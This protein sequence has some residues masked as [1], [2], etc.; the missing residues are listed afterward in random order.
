MNL[1]KDKVVVVTGGSSGI[2]RATVR[3]L[4]EGGAKVVIG[5][6]Q[7]CPD[8]FAG[9]G[10]AVF[11]TT[12]V[13]E[14]P[15]IDALIGEAIDRY[16]RIDHL[17]NNAGIGDGTPTDKLDA[18]TL[19]RVFSVNA[20]AVVYACGAVLPHMRRQSGGSIVNT[21]SIS[22]LAGDAATPAYNLTKGAVV[23]YTRALATELAG[24]NIRVNCVCPGVTD[25]P[26]VKGILATEA[27]RDGWMAAIPMGRPARPEEIAQVVAFLFSDWASYVHGAVIP[28][29]GGVM[30][31]TGFTD[32][33]PYLTEIM[34]NM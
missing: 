32:I 13:G 4:V 20:A 7:P 34:A 19:H 6:L 33:R 10:E 5:D 16:G 18:E 12:D 11:R 28:V 9:P 21:A 2:G 14:Q 8:E 27:V 15:Q 23:N 17:F 29:D 24:E 25:T 3:L 31:R 22:G 1:F 30:A 26:I